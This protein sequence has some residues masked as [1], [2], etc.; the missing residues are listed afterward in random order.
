M[1]S[2]G[3]YSGLN[4]LFKFNRLTFRDSFEAYASGHGLSSNWIGSM[5]RLFNKACPAPVSSSPV[6]SDLDRLI[7]K[8]NCLFE[9]MDISK[10]E[11]R[12]GYG[13]IFGNGLHLAIRMPKPLQRIKTGIPMFIPPVSQLFRRHFLRFPEML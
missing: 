12:L 2:F 7:Y 9:T 5:P 3:F 10:G 6:R 8:I 4:L 13:N 11:N 1:A